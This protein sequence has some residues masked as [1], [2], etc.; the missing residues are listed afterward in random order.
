M[1]N[2]AVQEAQM[3]QNEV[4][5]SRAEADKAIEEAR[6]FAEST[7]IKAIAEAEAISLRGD[8]L[9]RKSQSYSSLKQ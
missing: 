9:R 6:G 4:E 8:A 2:R 7:K 5:K 3:R 1:K